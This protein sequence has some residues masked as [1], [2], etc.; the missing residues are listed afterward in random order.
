VPFGGPGGASPLCA[1]PAIYF[2]GGRPAPGGPIMPFI[3]AVRDLGASGALVWA[4]PVGSPVPASFALDPRG[5]FWMLLTGHGSLQRRS[6]RTGAVM[7]SL[8]VT[9]L[10]GGVTPNVPWSV[11][12]VTG[13]ASAPVLV[14]GTVGGG[15]LS[16]HVIAVDLQTRSLVWKVNIAPTFGI[17]NPSVQFPIVLDPDGRPVL[18]FAGR[19]SGAYFLRDP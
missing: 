4:R 7:E 15:G 19:T 14:V 11:L 6:L 9:A 13:P 16:S 1:G 12:S 5:G 10:V 3:F 17:D 8:D 18:V 2:D